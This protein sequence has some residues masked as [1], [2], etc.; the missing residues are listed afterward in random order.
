VK[1]GIN[2]SVVLEIWQQEWYLSQTSLL[3]PCYPFIA[4]FL[5]D[6]NQHILNYHILQT[7]QHNPQGWI[8]DFAKGGHN[9][10]ETLSVRS[11]E[12]QSMSLPGGVCGYALQEILWRRNLISMRISK[13]SKSPH[14]SRDW[15]INVSQSGGWTRAGAWRI[16]TR[17]HD[18]LPYIPISFY[19]YDD[20]FTDTGGYHLM[21]GEHLLDSFLYNKIVSCALLLNTV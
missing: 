11:T 1:F 3:Y 7:I 18:S 5:E 4:K 21:H 14:K 19:H 10:I 15:L 17:E 8:Q 12:M 20:C 2:T 9:G 6:S 13:M 16:G